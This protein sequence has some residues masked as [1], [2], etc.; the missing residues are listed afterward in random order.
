LHYY[1]LVFYNSPLP[2][3]IFMASAKTKQ[4]KSSPKKEIVMNTR[5]MSSLTIL[6]NNLPNVSQN[7]TSPEMLLEQA[8]LNK[9]LKLPPLLFPKLCC[10]KIQAIISS[11]DRQRYICAFNM[12]NA[13]IYNQ[14]LSYHTRYNDSRYNYT[15]TAAIYLSVSSY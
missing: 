7:M 3:D 4:G 11:T 5:M 1:F 9:L 15:S 14:I 8:H 13:D 2:N 10:R 6:T 12:I